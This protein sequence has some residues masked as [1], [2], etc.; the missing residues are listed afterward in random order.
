VFG[1]IRLTNTEGVLVG[2]Q[3]LAERWEAEIGRMI[4][5]LTE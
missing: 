1:A 3:G 2:V 4:D 5:A